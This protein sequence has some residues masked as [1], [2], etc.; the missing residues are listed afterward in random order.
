MFKYVCTL[1]NNKLIVLPT[2][3]WVIWVL[4]K[5][6]S[7]CLDFGGVFVICISKSNT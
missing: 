1:L 5:R 4:P 7:K 3:I 2:T 6:M